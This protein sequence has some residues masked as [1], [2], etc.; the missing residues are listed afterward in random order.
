[1]TER[2]DDL[3]S[4]EDN[5]RERIPPQG[6]S[7]HHR[8]DVEGQFSDEDDAQREVDPDAPVKSDH[9]TQSHHGNRAEQ[10]RQSPDVVGHVGPRSK[11]DDESR[12]H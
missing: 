12:E 6:D 1:M 4:Q 10:T 2:K 3:K 7:R 9:P 11:D 5:S 8:K